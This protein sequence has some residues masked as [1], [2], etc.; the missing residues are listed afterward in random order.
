VS[1]P[2]PGRG[3]GDTCCRSPDPL[4]GESSPVAGGAGASLRVRS[5]PRGSWFVPW[6][7]EGNFGEPRTDN[8]VYRVSAPDAPAS[9]GRRTAVR[10]DSP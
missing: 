3:R 8:P 7:P 9:S 1:L 5:H 6:I 10:Y 2:K 4:M